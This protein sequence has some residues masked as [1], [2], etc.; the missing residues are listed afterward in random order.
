MKNTSP[1]YM[2]GS[3]LTLLHRRAY[4][5]FKEREKN[6]IASNNIPYNVGQK[7][8]LASELTPKSFSCDV[9]F[10]KVKLVTDG[11]WGTVQ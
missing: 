5:H 9:T 1:S 7:R 3:A 8:I 4:M 11:S 10:M 2:F 6:F